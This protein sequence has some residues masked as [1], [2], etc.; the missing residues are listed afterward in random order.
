MNCHSV[1]CENH[2]V[3]TMNIA[4]D[5]GNCPAPGGS[6][7]AVPPWPLTTTSYSAHAAQIGSYC[8]AW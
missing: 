8:G 7:P 5:D 2:D 3:S 1:R 4:P 6:G